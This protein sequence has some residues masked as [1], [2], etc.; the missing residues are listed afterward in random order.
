MLV[1]RA[2]LALQPLAL[3]ANLPEALSQSSGVW[4]VFL[5][6]ALVARGFTL[7]AAPLCFAMPLRCAA[8]LQAA[9]VALAAWHMPEACSTGYLA[10][11][12]TR[13]SLA[14]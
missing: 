2:L 6:L 9:A 1:C 11:P 7:L 4:C 8:V 13:R 5:R 10:L 12:A 3:G 14:E